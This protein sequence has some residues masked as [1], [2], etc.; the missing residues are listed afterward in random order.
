[1]GSAKRNRRVTAKAKQEPPSILKWC[2]MMRPQTAGLFLL[3]ILVLGTGLSVVRTTH[4]S[5]FVFN[6][7]QEL[8][9]QA[10]QQ[11][12]KWG[13]LLIEQSTFG[14]EGRIERKASEQLQ[15]QVPDLS[16]IV[17]VNND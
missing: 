8:K 10:N 5:R 11:E 17:M 15:M 3:L 7:L 1:M 12:I 16:R 9:D 2:G 4:Q 6:E 13:R 14:V